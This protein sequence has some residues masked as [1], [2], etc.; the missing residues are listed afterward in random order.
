MAAVNSTMQ[1][2]GTAAAQFALPDV[3]LPS[4]I[5]LATQENLV[6]L[7]DATSKPVLIMFICNHCPYV[8]HMIEPLVRLAN[9]AQ[10]NGFAV[11]A[12]SANDAQNYPQDSPSAMAKFAQRY[13]FEFPYLFDQSQQVAKAFEAACTP[14]FYVYDAAHRLVYRGQL[15]SSRLGN[16]QAI[17]GADLARGL[18]AAANRTTPPDKQIPSVGCNIKWRAGNEPDYF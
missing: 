13:G 11:F 3:T 17:T 7:S 14:D 12:I 4:E 5:G 1:D 10:L 16:G 6:T 15:D 9:E 2:L 18:S 8:I